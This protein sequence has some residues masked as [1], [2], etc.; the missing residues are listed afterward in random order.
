MIDRVG[1]VSMGAFV[2]V[3]DASGMDAEEMGAHR[4]E[5]WVRRRPLRP[6]RCPGTR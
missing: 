2:G 6:T 1:G 3:M 5:E 4:Y